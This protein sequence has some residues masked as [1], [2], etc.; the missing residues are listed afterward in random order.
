M[1]HTSK[2]HWQEDYNHVKLQLGLVVDGLDDK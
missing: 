1:F 2:M